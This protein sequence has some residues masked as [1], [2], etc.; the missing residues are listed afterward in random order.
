MALR[1]FMFRHVYTRDIVQREERK[2]EFMLESLFD[3]YRKHPEQ[4]PAE[5][6][7]GAQEDGVEQAVCDYIAG[8]TDNYAV[9][10]FTDLFIPRHE[11][12]LG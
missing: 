9:H 3:H 4:M 10:K 2:A 6:L 12:L 8:M 5:F 11:I 1:A 7:A